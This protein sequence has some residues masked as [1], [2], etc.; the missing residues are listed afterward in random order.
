MYHI[1]FISTF[2]SFSIL[3]HINNTAFTVHTPCFIY[4]I[5][6]YDRNFISGSVIHVLTRVQSDTLPFHW[7]AGFSGILPAE[8]GT[9]SRFTST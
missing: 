4:R 6:V 1:S 3:A 2:T 9:V 7:S 5:M 8:V